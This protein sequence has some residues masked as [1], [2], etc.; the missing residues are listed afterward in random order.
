MDEDFNKI[1]ESKFKPKFMTVAIKI[2]KNFK[3][4]PSCVHVDDT[5]RV[6]TV[7]KKR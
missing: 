7:A 1:F 2:K 4:I 6:Q 3:K 5:V